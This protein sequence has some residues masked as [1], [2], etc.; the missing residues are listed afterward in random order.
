MISSIWSVILCLGDPVE[1]PESDPPLEVESL[2]LLQG[3]LA[4]LLIVT[5][6]PEL[7]LLDRFERM[8]SEILDLGMVT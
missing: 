7:E 6:H 5:L 3:T 1:T 2:S 8:L 4:D